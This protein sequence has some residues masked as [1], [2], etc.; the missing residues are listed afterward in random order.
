MEELENGQGWKELS[1][2]VVLTLTKLADSVDE[3]EKELVRFREKL[4]LDLQA[5]REITRTE[6][7]KCQDKRDSGLERN[8]SCLDALIV[9]LSDRTHELEKNDPEH[10]V[11]QRIADLKDKWIFPLRLRM[12]VLSAFAGAAGGG[13]FLL[14]VDFL[15]KV[16]AET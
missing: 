1:K 8:L 11:D 3:N 14:L 7:C 4:L 5:L 9:K 12:A 2:Y 10:L 6:L 15:K 13:F 16:F